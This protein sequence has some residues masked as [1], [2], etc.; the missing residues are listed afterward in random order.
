MFFGTL[1]STHLIYRK[2]SATVGGNTLDVRDIFDIELTSFSTF[3][4]LASSLFMALAVSAIH[5]GNLKSTRWMLLGTIIFGSIFLACQVYE[6]THFVHGKEN[7]NGDLEHQLTLSAY[8]GKTLEDGKDAELK[9]HVFGST[10]LC[11]YRNSWN[12]CCNWCFLAFG[13]V[14]LL[15]YGENEY[16][17]RD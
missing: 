9:P 8:A 6:F 2:I 15:I 12:S 7:K 5:K 14:C 1:I 17:S 11:S 13:V 10:F 16:R 3:I 4:L